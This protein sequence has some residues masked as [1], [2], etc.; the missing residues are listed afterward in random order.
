MKL[1]ND[2]AAQADADQGLPEAGVNVVPDAL[3]R[4]K[5]V[6]WKVV[7]SVLEMVMDFAAATLRTEELATSAEIP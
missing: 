2:A 6:A 3:R 1:H 5:R 4:A 7:L